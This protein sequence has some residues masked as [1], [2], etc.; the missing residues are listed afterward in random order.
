MLHVGFISRAQALLA[1]K[2]RM[3]TTV[4]FA[5]ILVVAGHSHDGDSDDI[6]STLGDNVMFR[7]GLVK[8]KHIIGFSLFY[9]DH[10]HPSL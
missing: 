8:K 3:L 7:P 5:V 1:A 4:L 6:R 10:Y 9:N 2:A